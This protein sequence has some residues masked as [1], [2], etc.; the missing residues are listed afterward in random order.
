[1]PVYVT[2]SYKIRVYSP[3]TS[4]TESPNFPENLESGNDYMRSIAEIKSRLFPEN[5]SYLAICEFP[6]PEKPIAEK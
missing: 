3:N 2:S 4:G 6:M 5:E 1:M